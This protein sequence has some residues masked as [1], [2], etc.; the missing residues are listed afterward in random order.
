MVGAPFRTMVAPTSVANFYGACYGIALYFGDAV[1]GQARKFPDVRGEYQGC[2]AGADRIEVA[3][4]GIE[5]V[6]VDDCGASQVA[7]EA[8]D[9]FD[10]FP[11]GS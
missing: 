6:G 11:M 2:L 1:P 10:G 7:H 5:G 4:E 3:S 9:E 8:A